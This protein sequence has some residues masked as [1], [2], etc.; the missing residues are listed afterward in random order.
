MKK[1][2]L[3]LAI[4][5]FF[6]SGAC[7]TLF[8]WHMQDYTVAYAICFL[9]LSIIDLGFGIFNLKTFSEWE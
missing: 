3:I 9:V 4:T 6:L 5:E 8:I 1:L 2:A 7:F